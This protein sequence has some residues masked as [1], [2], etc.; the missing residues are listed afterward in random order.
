MCGIAGIFDLRAESRIDNSLLKKMSDVIYHRGP[1]SDGQWISPDNECGLAFRRL[2]IIDLSE[3]GN[4]P[5][6]T[7]DGR[8]H[9][10]FNGEIYNHNN[11]RTEF[12]YDG[13]KYNSRTDTE[14]ILYG[15][16]KYGTGFLEKMLG[17]WAIAIWD[18]FEKELFLSRDRIGIKPLYYYYKDEILIFGSE[19]KS[20][21]CHPDVRKEPEYQQIPIYLNYTMSSDTQTLFKNIRKLPAGS[22][23]KFKRGYEPSVHKYW[24]PLRNFSGYT[25][26]NKKEIEEHTINLLRDSISARMMSDVPFGVF[27]SGGIDS[28]LNVALMSELMSRP[29]DTF[30]VG[31]KELRKYNEL[32][33]ANKIAKLFKT[34][35]HEILIDEKDALPILENLA[36]HEDEP[37]GDPVCIPLYFLSKLTRES[38]TTVIQVGEGSDEQFIGYDWMKREYNFKN[39]FWKAFNLLPG[40]I[41]KFKSSIAINTA[42][43]IGR[44]DL[45]EYFRRAAADEELYWSGVSK[46]SPLMQE[47][48]FGSG[49]QHLKSQSWL[50]AKYMHNLVDVDFADA[51]YLQRMIYLEFHHRLAELLLMRVDKITMAHSLE[52]RVP[53]LDHR[54]VEF[55]MSLPPHIRLPE[56]G[57]TKSVLKKAVEGILPDDIIYRK[58]QGFAAPVKEWFRT[59][60]YDYAIN[61]VLAS[62]LVRGGLL[63]ADFIKKLFEMHKSGKRDYKN[64]LFLLLMISVWYRKFFGSQN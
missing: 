41:K 26:L 62:E 58:K 48:L 36:W 31:F 16:E 39:T 20:I 5:M 8:Y 2:S 44:Y 43:S 35:H 30:T 28:S 52:A 49:Y 32:E 9:I 51:D 40:F 38:G 47:D 12:E 3:S 21:L 56:S 50:F 54:F 27:L 46:I 7:A 18:N 25:E 61:E 29:V 59:S 64:E 14:T 24:S 13:K 57:L 22:F 60:W 33:Y 45:G 4:Q 1:D 10:V 34:N 15:Y 37:N 42:K 53:F 63:N 17:M 11:F 6:H 23:M 55:T 19:I